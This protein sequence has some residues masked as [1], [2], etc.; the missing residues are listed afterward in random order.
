LNET[1]ISE[2]NDKKELEKTMNMK[3][4]E[5]ENLQKAVNDLQ[6]NQKQEMRQKHDYI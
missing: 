5:I 1:L 3:E 4:N 2:L 6:R